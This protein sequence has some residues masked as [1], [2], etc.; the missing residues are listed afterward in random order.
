MIQDFFRVGNTKRQVLLVLRWLMII[1]TSFMI[2]FQH[3]NAILPLDLT[4]LI[5]LFVLSNLVLTF[6]PRRI[7]TSP[8]IYCMIVLVDTMIIGFC[9]YR[10]GLRSMDFYLVYFMIMLIAASGAEL[11]W[12]IFNTIILCAAY[13]VLLF[14]S[15][16]IQNLTDV[17]LYLRIPLLFIVSLLWFAA[18]TSPPRGRNI[19]ALRSPWSPETW[20]FVTFWLCHALWRGNAGNCPL[21]FGKTVVY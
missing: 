20:S 1:T 12:I 13:G 9:E 17:S 19:P 7:F 5:L 18:G 14:S 3:G 16:P 8:A 2:L 21:T 11:K 6:L 4:G 10:V 15:L